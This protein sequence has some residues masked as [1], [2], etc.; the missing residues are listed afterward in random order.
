MKEVLRLYKTHPGIRELGQMLCGDERQMYMSGAQASGL[1]MTFAAL[2]EVA[3]ETL[4]RVFLFVLD[5]AEEAGY[6]YHDLVQAL[7]ESGVLYF[8]GSF[9]RA[10]KYGQRD[11]ANEVLRTEVLGRIVSRSLPLFIVS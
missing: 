3:P 1:A 5:D 10:V 8:P 2:S 4:S 6:F 7:G 9:R 11:A